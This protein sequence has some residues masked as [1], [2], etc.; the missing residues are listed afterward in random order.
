MRALTSIQEPMCSF[1]RWFEDANKNFTSKERASPRGQNNR[2]GY[3][4]LL[5]E[6]TLRKYV[7]L[8]WDFV[9]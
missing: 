3:G 1:V 4:G 9:C 7:I 6:G 5:Q 8:L 2:N